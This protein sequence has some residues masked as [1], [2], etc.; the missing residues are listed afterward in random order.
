MYDYFGIFGLPFQ[1]CSVTPAASLLIDV[2]RTYL[3][4]VLPHEL[5][6]LCISLLTLR[7]CSSS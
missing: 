3:I 2:L 6:L 5:D 7:I 4:F 1:R